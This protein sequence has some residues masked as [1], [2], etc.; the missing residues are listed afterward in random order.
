MNNQLKNILSIALVIV[1]IVW[2]ILYVELTA[3]KVDK[4]GIISVE[5]VL[6]KYK[7]LNDISDKLDAKKSQYQELLNDLEKKVNEL[8]DASVIDSAKINMHI[9][10]YHALQAES[11]SEIQKLQQTLFSGTFNQINALVKEY[12]EENGYNIILGATSNGSVMY[13]KEVYNITDEVIAFINDK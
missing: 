7:G 2:P 6:E 8:S 12:A 3:K 5:K 9:Q 11:E 1:L 13:S 4:V 10:E